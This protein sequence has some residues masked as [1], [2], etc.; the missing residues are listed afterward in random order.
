MT[1]D[2]NGGKNDTESSDLTTSEDEEWSN[3]EG[4]LEPQLLPMVDRRRDKAHYGLR[5]NPQ[6]N[7]HSTLEDKLST[8]E[9]DVTL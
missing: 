2:N 7:R 6:H 1:I 8:A 5:Q 4:T 3:D 9:G